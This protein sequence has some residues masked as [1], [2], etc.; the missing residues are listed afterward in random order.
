MYE[1]PSVEAHHGLQN[2]SPRIHGTDVPAGGLMPE[3]PADF[4]CLHFLE[5]DL[6][7]QAR[8]FARDGWENGATCFFATQGMRL[9]LPGCRSAVTTGNSNT[10]FSNV[11]ISCGSQ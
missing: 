9:I 6:T 4:C 3:I 7:S 2:E 10:N 1:I 8:R 11:A 5:G